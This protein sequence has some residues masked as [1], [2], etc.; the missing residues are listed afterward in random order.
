MTGANFGDRMAVMSTP[1][2]KTETKQGNHAFASPP[3]ED[4]GFT[5]E[6]LSEMETSGSS[7]VTSVTEPKE[8]EYDWSQYTSFELPLEDSQME[9]ESHHQRFENQYT[10]ASF[11]NYGFMNVFPHGFP[12][13]AHEGIEQDSFLSNVLSGELPSTS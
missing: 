3:C 11:W 12:H 6:E 9:C 2:V 10:A 1:F 8:E 5:M 4:D 13:G 7:D